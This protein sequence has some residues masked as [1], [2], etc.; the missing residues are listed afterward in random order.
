MTRGLYMQLKPVSRS[1]KN[2]VFQVLAA[3]WT[4][5]NSEMVEVGTLT[6]DTYRQTATFTTAGP[7]QREKIASPFSNRPLAVLTSDGMWPR[8][9]L[10][11]GA[12]ALGGSSSLTRAV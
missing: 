5:D 3:G 4:G 2:L 7:W 8:W 12:K 1:Q 9:L 11:L 6:L 10:E